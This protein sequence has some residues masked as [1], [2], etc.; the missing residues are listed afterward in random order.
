MWGFPRTQEPG[1]PGGKPKWSSGL[2]VEPGLR[3]D[4][5][6]SAGRNSKKCCHQARKCGK[7]VSDEERSEEPAPLWLRNLPSSDD[8][9]LRLEPRGNSLRSS[10]GVARSTESKSR[11][12]PR[13]AEGQSSLTTEKMKQ[14]SGIPLPR[15]LWALVLPSVGIPKCQLRVSDHKQNGAFPELQRSWDQSTKCGRGSG[16]MRPRLG[17]AYSF[18]QH[19]RDRLS[20][21]CFQRITGIDKWL[22]SC[23]P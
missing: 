18:Y 22:R 9:P 17:G 4:P 6:P 14:H 2:A 10:Q 16:R 21:C 8:P 23:I 1:G 12:V 5:D 3:F 20:I 11:A 19:G 15:N 7:V 13:T